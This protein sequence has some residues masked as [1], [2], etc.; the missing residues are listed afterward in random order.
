MAIFGTV[1]LAHY[2]TAMSTFQ[3]HKRASTTKREIISLDVDDVCRERER[4][5]KFASIIHRL[6]SL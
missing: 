6:N 5:H 2:C 1:F 4:F 3:N